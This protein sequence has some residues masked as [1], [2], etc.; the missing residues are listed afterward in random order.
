MPP[1]RR[2]RS[3]GR[4]GA[5]P[6][7]APALHVSTETASF[8]SAV[9]GMVFALYRIVGAC[10]VILYYLYLFVVR[11]NTYD[12]AYCT[13]SYELVVRI[14]KELELL[15]DKCEDCEGSTGIHSKLNSMDTTGFSRGM[16]SSLRFCATLRN[17]L[18]HTYDLHSFSRSDHERLLNRYQHAKVGLLSLLEKKKKRE[19]AVFVEGAPESDVAII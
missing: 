18:L 4:R 10:Y 9:N 19:T 5:R 14:S 2:R 6:G 12:L 15:L 17:K 13:N 7:S 3:V 8:S 1:A 11:P 16:I